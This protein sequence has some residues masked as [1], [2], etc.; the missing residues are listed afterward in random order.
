MNKNQRIKEL[1]LRYFWEQKRKE[2][3]WFFVISVSVMFIP[4]LLGHNI[5]D[6]TDELCGSEERHY[7]SEIQR[8]EGECHPIVLWIEGIIYILMGA[9]GLLLLGL[10]LLFI[11]TLFE[12]WIT[13]N[14]KKAKK[15]ARKE[16]KGNGK[17]KAK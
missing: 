14:W 1:T 3:F 9:G 13:S 4:Y 11:Y 7:N 15:R 2:V 6:N 16:V 10:I 5:G 8:W 17:R 12:S